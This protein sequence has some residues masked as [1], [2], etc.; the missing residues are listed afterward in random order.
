[1][2]FTCHTR[3]FVAATCRGDVSQ[4]FVASCVS[5]LMDSAHAQLNGYLTVDNL[6]EPLQS[7]C[8]AFHSSGTA[9]VTVMNDVILTLEEGENIFILL[10]D[11]SAAF[12]T[13]NHSLLL[14]RLEIPLGMALLG[15]LFICFNRTFLN[16]RFQFVT[17][18]CVNAHCTMRDLTLG[19]PQGSVLGPILYLLYTS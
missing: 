15:L 17:M 1:M 2:I 4:R 9:L 6:N 3:R 7:S 8:K 16:D 19:V 13:V 11:L 5:A 10:L 14:S 18:R 12:D